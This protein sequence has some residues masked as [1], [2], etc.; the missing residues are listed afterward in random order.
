[1]KFMRCNGVGE[2]ANTFGRIEDGILHVDLGF[3]KL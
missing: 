2:V 3:S 1:M